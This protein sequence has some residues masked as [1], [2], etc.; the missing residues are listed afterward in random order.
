M[1]EKS[2]VNRFT[3]IT[4]AHAFMLLPNSRLKAVKKSLRNVDY[5]LKA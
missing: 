3:F 2:S 1:M 4:M 5:Q